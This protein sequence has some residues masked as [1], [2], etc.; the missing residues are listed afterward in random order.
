MITVPIE[1][2][3]PQ[4]EV[5]HKGLYDLDSMY[6]GIRAWLD[7]RRYDYNE[8]RYKDKIAD[9][10]NEVEHEMEAELKVTDF[11]KFDI[12]I[13]TKFYGVKEFESEFKGKKRMVN[14][15]QFFIQIKG[16]V[17]FD[18]KGN[19]KSDYFLNLLVRR[20]LKNYYD[21]KYVDRLYYDLYNLQ[22]LIKEQSYMETATNAY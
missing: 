6:K 7:E 21:V 10:G 22:T 3:I 11:V 4:I 12:E 14:K 9:Y 1:E 18:Y 13:V 8:K 5:R 15:G 16:K 2:N 20:L 17:T 19:F